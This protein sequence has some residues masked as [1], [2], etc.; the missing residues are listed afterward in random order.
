IAQFAFRII[1]PRALDLPSLHRALVCNGL[2]YIPFE[3][4]DSHAQDSGR[5]LNPALSEHKK[6]QTSTC[7]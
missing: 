4:A 6:S 3:A 2:I 7:V 1:V 5:D